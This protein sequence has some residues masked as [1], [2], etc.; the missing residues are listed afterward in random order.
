M[1]RDNKGVTG[2]VI[3]NGSST[4]ASALM[5]AA[6]ADVIQMNKAAASVTLNNYGTMTSL[7]A[8]KGGAQTIDFAAIQSGSNVVCNYA[9]GVIQAQDADAVRPGVN[10]EVNNWGTIR[11]TNTT[12]TGADSIDAQNNT[13]VTISN[14]ATGSITGARHGITGGA[15]AAVD[16]FTTTIINAGTIT[17]NDGGGI[18]LDGFN[19]NQT[20]T[21]TN[22]GTISGNGVT[23]DGD[24]IDADGVVNITNTGIIRSVNAYSSDSSAPA[25]SEGI[26]AG[27]GTITNSGTIEG[28]VASGNT[29]AVGRGI[30]LAGVD[31][32]GTPEAIYANSVITNQSGGL[33]R[34]QSDS[35]IVV[36]GPASGFTVTIDNHA[37]ATIQ[38]G[39]S[40]NAAIR[41]GA[42]NDT[43]INAGII[44]G[45]SSGKAIDMG[46]GNNTLTISGGSASVL[47]N[48][49]GGV[50]GSNTM[51]L[52]PG[53]GNSFA[54]GGSISNFDTVEIISGIVTLSGV[55]DSIG[56]TLL[57][58]GILQLDGVDRLSSGSLLALN[59]GELEILNAG[60]ADG[61]TFASLALID[62]STIDLNAT[63]LTFNGLGIIGKGLNL[64]LMDFLGTPSLDY[65]FRL[66]GDYST[67]A[68]FLRLMSGTTI[69]GGAVAFSFDGSY[70][71]VSGAPVPEPATFA[72]MITGLSLMTAMVRRKGKS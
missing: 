3:N 36:G 70:T 66:A 64:S 43:I 8:S 46:A 12:D 24:G 56:T 4:N 72:M 57:S 51:T 27:G 6:D 11:A 48:I 52:D 16:T 5:Q 62:N 17:G 58:G 40:S 26:T 37:G 53:A 1:V 33:L 30:T 32:S 25:Q 61:Q 15:K 50:D 21:I 22:S 2:L 20:A 34:G 55:S 18:N 65:A 44:D 19:A 23:G 14:Y 59:G 29:N 38:G 41:T 35:A 10:G 39:G 67:D 28:L 54:Y 69:N 45:F 71:E 68:D 49:N 60:G 42:D 7:N 47:G 9:T 31:T 13:G 63:A